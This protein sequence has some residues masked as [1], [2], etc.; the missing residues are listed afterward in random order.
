M[1]RRSFR[2]AVAALALAL[3]APPARAVPAVPLSPDNPEIADQWVNEAVRPG[4]GELATVELV[5]APT[6]TSAHDPFHVKLRITNHTDETLD[7]LKIVP[8]R[9]APVG[10]VVEQRVAAVAGVGEYEPVGDEGVVDKRIAPGESVETEMTLKAPGGIGTYP[11]L[12]EL[13]DATGT[14][15]DTERF[16]L[17]VRGSDDEEP[18]EVTALYPVSAPV[19]I[20][21]GETGEAP[22]NPPLV[23]ESEELADQLAPGGRLDKLVEQYLDAVETP[24]V[25]YATCMAL[26]P[27]LV[28]T[29][30][31]MAGGYTV[32]DTRNAVVEEP[33]RLR[34]SWGTGDDTHA[35]PGRGADDAKAWLDKIRQVSDQGCTVALP[36]ANADLNAV[37]RTGDEWLM[38]EAVERGPFVLQRVLGNAGTINTV[39]SGPG[40]VEQGAA[41][42]LGWA[43]HTRSTVPDGGMQAA[44]EEAHTNEAPQQ[45]PTRQ[46]ALDSQQMADFAGAAAPQPARPVRVLAAQNASAERFSWIAPGVMQVGY[47]DSLAGVLASTGTHPDTPGY[48]NPSLRF[49]ATLDSKKARDLSAAA[50]MRQAARDQV[51]FNPPA[52]WDADT[53]AVLLG[54]VASIIADGTARPISFGAYLAAPPDV[55]P[56]ERT[57]TNFPDPAAY[58][59]AEILQVTQQNSFINDITALMVP[60]PAIAL[61]R[62]GFTLPLRRDMLAALTTNDRRALSLYDDTTRA[63]G[64]RL[65]ASRT[66]LNELRDSVTLIPPGNVYTRASSSSPLLIVAQNGMPLPVR[67]EIRYFGRDDARLN[68][69]GTL[70]I[71]ARGSVTVQMT[72]DLP[73]T[74]RGTELQLY[75]AGAS[76]QPISRPV[77]IAVRT[78][79]LE[80]RGWVIGAALVVAAL[81]LALLTRFKRSKAPPNQR[82]TSRPAQRTRRERRQP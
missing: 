22:E 1:M 46:N 41:P 29:V 10:S 31:R 54:T 15:L 17:G 77:D 28:D 69:P 32:S 11:M 55:A 63:T 4:E 58:T 74:N 33:K 60:D 13:V 39:V 34:D 64:K 80:V 52:T 79:G 70:K 18:G 72:A 14:S 75:L 44:W 3:A 78:A 30:D 23:L 8:R 26:D 40:Y 66:T 76:G 24:E 59:E 42:A 62:Y 50:A 71:P 43:D 21:P 20:V 57:G 49:D 35:A 27:A 73:E 56:A 48:T 37:A 36:W 25:G 6:S 16:H 5:D 61:T 47:Q 82:A 9:A 19:D 68:V 67:T 51:L 12:L 7:S 38:R 45:K 81:T 2:L 65:T 53:A